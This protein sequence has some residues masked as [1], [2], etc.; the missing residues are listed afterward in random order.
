MAASD[1]AVVEDLY[2]GMDTAMFIAADIQRALASGSDSGLITLLLYSVYRV[3]YLTC[4][5][6]VYR[7]HQG[8]C[9][10]GA[11]CGSGRWCCGGPVRAGS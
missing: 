10:C 11:L 3:I 8:F 1:H 2:K 9:A 7:W 6:W 4:T 5:H